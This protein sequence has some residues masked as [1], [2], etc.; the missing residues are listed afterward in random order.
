[1]AESKSRDAG[2]AGGASEVEAKAPPVA[3]RSKATKASVAKR[4]KA[5]KASVAKKSDEA[6][7]APV[8]KKATAPKRRKL[9]IG[10]HVIYADPEPPTPEPIDTCSI[11]GRSLVDGLCPVHSGE[12]S[13]WAVVPEQGTPRSR[14]EE[15]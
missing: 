5:T 10:G 12:G 2:A 3:K 4:S 13:G 14:A 6:A 15:G 11:C 8:A 7:E 1:M 9:N